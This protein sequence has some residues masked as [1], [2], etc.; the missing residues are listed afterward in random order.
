MSNGYSDVDV[1]VAPATPFRT[2]APLAIIR[3]SGE[4]SLE[5]LARCFQPRHGELKGSWRVHYGDWI[6]GEGMV[7][8]VVVSTFRAPRS[9]TGQD[10]FEVS[11]HGNPVFVEAILQS[12]LKEGGRR[13]RPGE[14]TMRA[15]L[16]GKMDL[17]QAEGVNALIDCN[18]RYQAGLIR[19]QA[20][21]PLVDFVHRQVEEILQI[22]AHIEATIDYGEEDIDALERDSL[23]GRLA[24]LISRF[25]KL[26]QTAAFANSMRRGFKVLLTGEPNVGKST[27]FNA[28]V[29]Q[30]RAIVTELPG[31]TRDLISE[32]IEMQGLPVI[33]ID[34]AGVRQT[35]D[36]IENIGIEKIYQT[37][38]QVDLVLFL[39]A[40]GDAMEPYPRLRELPEEKWLHVQTK[41][42]L[43]PSDGENDLEKEGRICVSAATG[44]GLQR[45]ES[46]IVLRLSTD[47][48]DQSVYL[49]N[50]RQEEIISTVIQQ[51]Q[52]A[53][54]DFDMGFGEEV[55]SSYLNTARQQ[56]GELTG[57][58]T[59]EDILDRMFSNFCLGK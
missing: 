34:S 40:A 14:F 33:L 1:I 5:L 3:V 11:C 2:K 29:R 49:I 6:D 43:Q 26:H 13:A 8:D 25:Q 28:L 10:M 54:D 7:D 20:K 58:T 19:R 59:V 30:E 27:L 45:L 9:Y 36:V 4:K 22:Q 37:L 44:M 41:A 32:E 31:T 38:E 56:L 51:L 39:S 21:G 48:E 47:F 53:Y 24:Q 52:N 57:E 55:L 17:L 16:N 15:V 50:Q 12:I 18:T 23:G 46:E 42:D 35:D